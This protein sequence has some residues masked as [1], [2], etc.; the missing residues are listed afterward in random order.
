ELTLLGQHFE[1][2]SLENG[3]IPFNVL[4]CVRREYKKSGVDR[5]AIAGGL[6]GERA[7]LG[8]CSHEGPKASAWPHRSDGSEFIMRLVKRDQG[9]NVNVG[10][11]VTVGHT[12]CLIV[13]DKW[14]NSFQA[15]S[16][17]R[18]IAG[19]DQRYA[20]GFSGLAV[21]SYLAGSEVDGQVA[22]VKLIVRKIFF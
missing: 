21:K 14:S 5:A 9:G 10:N 22:R 18:E 19:I 7:N 15:T 16:S 12:E 17:L 11:S 20:P 4:K 1:R 8:S 2:F 13:S 3:R 6:L